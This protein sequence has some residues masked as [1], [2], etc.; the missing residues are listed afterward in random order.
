M[1]PQDT[2]ASPLLI[3]LNKVFASCTWAQPII[4]ALG[5]FLPHIM[6]VNKYLSLPLN[7]LKILMIQ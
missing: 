3:H 4:Q 1:F 7:L 5:V 2:P 6:P